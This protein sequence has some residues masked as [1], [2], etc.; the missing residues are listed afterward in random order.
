M[1]VKLAVYLVVRMAG[2]KDYMMAGLKAVS[3]ADLKA[4]LKVVHWDVKLAAL[5][6]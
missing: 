6:A 4:A 3:M 5:L 1:A 2:K